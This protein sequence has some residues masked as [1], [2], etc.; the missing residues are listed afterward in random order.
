MDL[1]S[2]AFKGDFVHGQFHQVDAAPVFGT[3][4]F[5]R[6]RIRNL[7]EVESWSLIPDYDGQSSTTF[8]AATDVNQLAWVYAIAVDHRITQGFP[9]REFNELFLSVNTARGHDQSHKPI[10]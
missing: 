4:V 6:Q 8:T 9:E 7:I 3:E 5:D 2:S 1:R 10:H